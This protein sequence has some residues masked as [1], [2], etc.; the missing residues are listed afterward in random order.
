[1]HACVCIYTC[2]QI[3]EYVYIHTHTN[4]HGMLYTAFDYTCQK[5][6]DE[7]NCFFQSALLLP[8]IIPQ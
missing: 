4:T 3:Y 8:M 6:I 1:M 7:V 2:I 5:H